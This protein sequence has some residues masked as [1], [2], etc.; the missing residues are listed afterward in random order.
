MAENMALCKLGL[1]E[2]PYSASA[3]EL[4]TFRAPLEQTSRKKFLMLVQY[5]CKI[6]VHTCRHNACAA[7]GALQ[8]AIPR[9]FLFL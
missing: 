8:I 9:F 3:E 1:E 4:D 2:N 5:M 7:H 6:A